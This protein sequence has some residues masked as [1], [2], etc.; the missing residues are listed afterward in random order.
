VHLDAGLAE[1][2]AVTAVADELA[3]AGA[4]LDVDAFGGDVGAQGVLDDAVAVAAFGQAAVEDDAL[5][6]PSAP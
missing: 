6:G 5:F 4:F 2:G 1:A 3:A